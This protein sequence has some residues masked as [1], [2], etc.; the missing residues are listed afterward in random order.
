M[1]LM[2][3][4]RER[5]RGSGSGL[6]V[7]HPQKVVVRRKPLS[8]SAGL[9]IIPIGGVA[10]PMNLFPTVLEAEKQDQG[11]TVGRF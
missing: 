1:Q 4:R 9:T 10:Y 5:K 6:R 11:A 3:G 7:S 2:A 8:R